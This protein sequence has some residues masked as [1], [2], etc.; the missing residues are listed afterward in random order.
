MIEV[1]V[2]AEKIKSIYSERNSASNEKKWQK[3]CFVSQ[4]LKGKSLLDIG[5]SDG[6]FTNLVSE[7][8]LFDR[9]VSVD[10]KRHSKLQILSEKIKF[11]KVK[12][13]NLNFKT[14]EFE[15]VVC[16]EVLE[17]LGLH[18]NK[19]EQLW[20]GW[21]LSEFYVVLN[22]ARRIASKRLLLTVPFEETFPI[23]KHDQ[24]TGHK[25]IFQP[26]KLVSLF[27]TAKFVRLHHWLLIIEDNP[28]HIEFQLSSIDD[29]LRG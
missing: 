5:T 29:L 3:L 24:A 14:D 7:L 28:V 10:E 19:E 26:N 23:Y 18:R 1:L 12:F 15:T 22:E 4:F 17:H 20:L 25:Q 13:Q 2:A 16:M 6:C 11:E 9:I 27:P 21:D 8:N